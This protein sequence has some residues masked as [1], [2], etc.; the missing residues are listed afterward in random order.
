MH[1]IQQWTI[2]QVLT[3]ISF[4]WKIAPLTVLQ[5]PKEGIRLDIVQEGP[6]YKCWANFYMQVFDGL[7]WES[8]HD[9]RMQVLGK[10][11]TICA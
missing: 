4:F 9:T 5:V 1:N 7:D 3:L 11:L 10:T 8:F 6:R 2:V